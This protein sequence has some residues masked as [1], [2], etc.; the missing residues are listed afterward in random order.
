MK[1]KYEDRI[2][3]LRN[4]QEISELKIRL[5]ESEMEIRGHEIRALYA[6]EDEDMRNCIEM[7]GTQCTTQKP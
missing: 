3:A 7:E 2:L 6:K 5:L 1:S 4:E